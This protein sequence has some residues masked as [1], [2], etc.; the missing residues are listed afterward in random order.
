MTKR[1]QLP[2]RPVI[3]S[4]HKRITFMARFA[5]YGARR[6]LSTPRLASEE[7]LPKGPSI[8]HNVRSWR[9]RYLGASH[10]KKGRILDE[11]VA[12]TSYLR[13]SAILPLRH[14]Y[15]LDTWT[16]GV[17]GGRPLL[18]GEHQRRIPPHPALSPPRNDQAQTTYQRALASP[19]VGE[20][21]KAR[22]Q[23][24]CRTLNPVEL[25][26]RVQRNLERLRGVP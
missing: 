26:L 24:L 6:G 14:A 8:P 22:L 18:V 20:E 4:R 13:K 9:P 16:A 25:Q 12:L 5:I 21:D 2:S 17:P 7:L 10:K 19:L 1:M 15:P 11:F 3:T 23:E